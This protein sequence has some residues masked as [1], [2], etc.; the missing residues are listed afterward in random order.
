MNVNF[1]L[2]ARKALLLSVAIGCLAFLFWSGGWFS[3]VLVPPE[4]VFPGLAPY[5]V[6]LAALFS[7]P[8]EEV[9]PATL[10]VPSR[11]EMLA[12]G[13]RDLADLLQEISFTSATGSPVYLTILEDRLWKE[14][15][16][17]GLLRVIPYSR[18]ADTFGR[19]RW[20]T[21][22]AGVFAQSAP[23][24]QLLEHLQEKG[25][26]QLYLV[27]ATHREGRSFHVVMAGDYQGLGNAE[28]IRDRLGT[29]DGQPSLVAFSEPLSTGPLRDSLAAPALPPEPEPPPPEPSPT[30]PETPEPV[31]E[32]VVE[33]SGNPSPFTLR[34]A[35]YNTRDDARRGV[36]WYAKHRSVTTFLVKP[37]RP[38]R[39]GW[40][41]YAGDFPDEN[42]ALAF[43]RSH[44]LMESLVR[45]KP[46]TLRLDTS[47]KDTERRLIELGYGPYRLDAAPAALFAGLFDE[48]ATATAWA[49]DLSKK[50]I[51]ATVVKRSGGANGG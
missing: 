40:V 30:A 14:R 33:T 43:R 6:R 37:E 1:S 12:R 47:D 45:R 42:T 25:E 8:M 32:P 46:Y 19:D 29:A 50:G 38:G 22:V 34:V 2:D 48:E 4:T 41:I 17:D 44:Q 24:K 51:Q 39:C 18:V 13:V 26:R 20:F 11:E 16:D 5:S 10:T 49:E 3:S 28:A 7:R 21:V 15:L 31:V 9:R 36:D 23:A 35:C 27:S